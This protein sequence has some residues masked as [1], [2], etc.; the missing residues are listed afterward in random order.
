MA[1]RLLTKNEDSEEEQTALAS[2]TDYL[3]DSCSKLM[4]NHLEQSRPSFSQIRS[5]L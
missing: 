2:A 5:I 4:T 1:A 3:S